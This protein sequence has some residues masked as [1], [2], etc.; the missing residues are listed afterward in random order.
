MTRVQVVQRSADSDL[1]ASAKNDAPCAYAYRPVATDKL[2]APRVKKLRSKLR[3]CNPAGTQLGF[4]SIQS[5]HAA[6]QTRAPSTRISSLLSCPE[7]GLSLQHDLLLLP[8]LRFVSPSARV[9]VVIAMMMMVMATMI[10]M[11][12]MITM[13]TMMMKPD[14]C[15]S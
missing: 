14:C 5:P 9:V 2:T 3:P 6:F 13:T 7:P 1:S 11:I 8:M 10:T 15:S 4:L 12:T